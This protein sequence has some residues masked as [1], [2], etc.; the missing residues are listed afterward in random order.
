MAH[1]GQSRWSCGVAFEEDVVGELPEDETVRR[2]LTEKDPAG[3]LYLPFMGTSASDHGT[4]EYHWV[5]I[6]TPDAMR[7]KIGRSGSWIHSQAEVNMLIGLANRQ[8]ETALK[9]CS[10]PS[11]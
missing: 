2:F 4:I 6:N 1:K 3:D 10:A 8:P 11:L 9:R 7:Q 5:K